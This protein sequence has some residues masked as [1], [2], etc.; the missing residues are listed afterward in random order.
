[1]WKVA[2]VPKAFGG[3][4]AGRSLGKPCKPLAATRSVKSTANA[5][6]P[7]QIQS[8]PTVQLSPA[9]NRDIHAFVALANRDQQ[10]T[11][12]P[13][14]PGCRA[15]DSACNPLVFDVAILPGTAGGYVQVSTPDSLN[16]FFTARDTNP[17]LLS[18]W[19]YAGQPL[20]G[21]SW[22]MLESFSHARKLF[23]QIST[24]FPRPVPRSKPWEPLLYM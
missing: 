13:R 18:L 17:G 9:I 22:I 10:T 23:G 19:I 1:M 5:W 4:K 12:R 21:H 3:S 8:N 14:S 16:Q 11:P 15:D 24:D 20:P 2:F 7:L 6:I